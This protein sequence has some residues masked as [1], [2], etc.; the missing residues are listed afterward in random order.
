MKTG[1]LERIATKAYELYERN[2]RREGGELLDWL[3]AEKIVQY[4]RMIIPDIGGESMALLDYRP[5]Y[6]ERTT[7][8]SA[9][10]AK[11][12]SGKVSRRGRSVSASY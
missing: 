6:E 3:A 11:P 2:G 12:R 4:E 1:L 8:P 7:Q 10:K 9:K 5:A